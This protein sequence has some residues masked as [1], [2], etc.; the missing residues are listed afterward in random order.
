MAKYSTQIRTIIETGY[1]IF[2][3]DYPIFDEK[4][5][6]VLEKKILDRYFFR[7]IGF[8]TVAQF[9]HF[10]RTRMNEIMPYYNQHYVANN[11]FKTYDPYKNK[12]FF[13][14]DERN[15][16]GNN[17]NNS[18]GSSTNTEKTV[19]N[20]TPTSKL[21]T[22]DYATNITDSNDQ[23]NNTGESSGEFEN[24]ETYIS[25]LHGHDGMKYPSDILRDLRNT[26][27]NI[28]VEIIEE[29]S[30]LFMNVY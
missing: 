21:G 20:D 10:L 24:T 23:N 13:I 12:D 15:T 18:S 27:N 9:K 30:D 16:T 5:R 22:E 11:I 19:F 17:S 3:F 4:Y 26:F 25:H 8:E 1:K 7:E 28:D 6:S 29:L 14:E 2:D